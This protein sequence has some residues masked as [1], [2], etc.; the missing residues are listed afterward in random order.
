[1]HTTHLIRAVDPVAHSE[2]GGKVARALAA[3]LVVVV[4][5]VGP[6]VEGDQPREAPREVIAAGKRT[7]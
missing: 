6:A 1:M 3:H 4:V 5:E 2:D 7:K